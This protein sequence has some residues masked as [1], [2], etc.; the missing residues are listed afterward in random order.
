MQKHGEIAIKG[1]QVMKG[2]WNK[3]RVKRPI[4]RS[5]NEIFKG[6]NIKPNE[7]LK[8]N[9]LFPFMK[10]KSLSLAS[11]KKPTNKTKTCHS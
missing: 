7:T 5:R 11:L 3:P 10:Q 4:T 9:F 6:E 8:R 1:P 2:Y